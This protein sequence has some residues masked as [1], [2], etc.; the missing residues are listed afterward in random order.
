MGEFRYRAEGWDR[1]RRLV[2]IRE[3][4]KEGKNKKQPALIELQG[5]S[6][7]VIVT[8]QEELA[9]E[10]AGECGERDLL[11]GLKEGCW[12]WSSA[13]ALARGS[14]A[15]KAGESGRL[16]DVRRFHLPLETIQSRPSAASCKYLGLLP[17]RIP[18]DLTAS[19]RG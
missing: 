13:D 11:W 8:N 1:E 2:V 15:G 4:V 10:E 5:H 18:V 16:G 6:C 14:E 12:P 9:P 3:V 7:Q 19:G 17:C